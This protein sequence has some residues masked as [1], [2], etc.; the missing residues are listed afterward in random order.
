MNT[1]HLFDKPTT[2]TIHAGSGKHISARTLFTHLR[3]ALAEHDLS[4][5]TS[6]TIAGDGS[7]LV[8]GEMVYQP[9]RS[10]NMFQRRIPQTTA[11]KVRG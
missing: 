5:V 11:K 9:K 2:I 3:E 10:F 6:I 8:D 1:L 7:V 4:G